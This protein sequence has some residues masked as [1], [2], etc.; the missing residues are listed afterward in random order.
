MKSRE[1][2]VPAR[3]AQT[4]AVFIVTSMLSLLILSKATP[5]VWEDH[6]QI[7][8][9][10]R[11]TGALTVD[12]VPSFIRPPGFP[13]FVAA[14]L[15]IGDL[16]PAAKGAPDERPANRDRRIVVSAQGLLLGAM[17]AALFLWA[18]LWSG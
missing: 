12:D 11:S 18:S 13:G 8:Q 17:A 16:I 3:L 15:W 7:G 4:A 6:F 9:H 10:L 5:M 14:S 2:G 1:I